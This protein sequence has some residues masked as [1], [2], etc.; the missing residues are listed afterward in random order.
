MEFSAKEAAVLESINAKVGAAESVDEIVRQVFESTT[1][2]FPCD[3]I[4]LAFLEDDGRHL[5]TKVVHAAYEPVLLGADY[6][7]DIGDGSLRAILD[8]GKPRII[9]D[10]ENHLNE[11][12][13]SES[14][15]LL[16]REG[17]RSN[18]TCPLVVNGRHVGVMFRSSRQTH[19]YTPRHVSLHMAIVER[20]SQAVEKAYRIEQLADAKRSYGEVL[21][22]VS[23]ELKN[24]LTAILGDVW[25]LRHDQDRELTAG[26]A[27]SVR[28]LQAKVDYLVGLSREYLD[29]GK[30]HDD[31][32][33]VQVSHVDFA[34]EVIEPAIG[35]YR[36]QLEQKRMRLELVPGP[37]GSAVPCDA[38]LLRIAMNNLISNAIKYG[39]EGGAIR[40]RWEQA[41]DTFRVY[42]FNE[43]PGFP[44]EQRPRLFRRFSR[45]QTPELRRQPGTGIGLYNTWR[46]VRLHQGKIAADSL[47][48]RWAE[49]CMEIPLAGSARLGL[50]RTDHGPCGTMPEA[51][52]D[53]GPASAG[54]RDTE[55]GDAS[56]SQSRRVVTSERDERAAADG[57][58][59]VLCI[60]DDAE[61][62]SAITARLR[63][64]GLDVLRA[65]SGMQGYWMALESRPDV[66]VTDLSMPDGEGNYIIGRLKSHPLTERTP[67]I[68]LAGQTNPAVKRH[69]LGLGVDA[70]LTKPMD[71]TQLVNALRRHIDLPEREPQLAGWAT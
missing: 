3:R 6:A 9:N 50:I 21:S 71:W 32:L 35:M 65:F 40:I 38:D 29:L 57:R 33:A 34:V 53:T 51:S 62:S 31:D 18:L 14:T 60:D 4:G 58:V 55:A 47:P 67:I 64:H 44:P 7:A 70:Y 45:V 37:S 59:K 41:D 1:E 69:I 66:V 27:A 24:A 43:G 5:V 48:G 17:I 13:R 15:R 23:H 10:L 8:E 20:L 39:R 12:P 16:L 36:T 52:R 46:I 54:C 56:I 49:F 42:V 63:R 28:R 19:A 30:L 68:V 61:I 11:H 2:I 22:F 25:C 26:Q